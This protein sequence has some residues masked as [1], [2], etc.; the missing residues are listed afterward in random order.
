MRR[1]SLEN[2]CHDKQA[3]FTDR[4]SP[5]D[6]VLLHNYCLVPKLPY[7]GSVTASSLVLDLD[8]YSYLSTYTINHNQ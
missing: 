1:E 6:D 8:R 2:Q 5:K 4:G 7:T 3:L